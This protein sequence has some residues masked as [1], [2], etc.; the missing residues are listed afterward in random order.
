[1]N[2]K[3]VV[4]SDFSLPAEFPF[5]AMRAQGKQ[6]T[7]QVVHWHDCLE[8]NW[9][10]SGQ[11][12]NY[13]ADR[14]YLLQPGQLYLINNV[15][16]HIAVTDGS[17]DMRIVV[18]EPSL[19]WNTAAEQQEYLRM[20]FPVGPDAGNLA[21]LEGETLSRARTL[22]LDMEREWGARERGYELML[23][24][25][26][27]ELLALL[28]R[29]MPETMEAKEAAALRKGYQRIRPALNHIQSHYAEPISLEALAALCGM[30]RTYFCTL[31]KKTIGMNFGAYLEKVRVSRACMLLATSDLPVL[32]IAL[33]SGFSSLS[34]FNAAFKSECKKTPS[35]YRRDLP[36]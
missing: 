29:A 34:S 5:A 24:A 8:I 13:I 23:R 31:F 21:P 11:G 20:F 4:K 35:Q 3:I 30:S 33:E 28:Y 9:I 17:L 10:E 18:F 16:R 36:V 6:S 32:D 12:V 1:M 19:L 25:R 26:L 7:P 2:P 22:M 15:D 14:E 27:T